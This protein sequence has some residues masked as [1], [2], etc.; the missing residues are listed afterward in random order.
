M[1]VKSLTF[2]VLAF[3]LID[4]FDA[5]TASSK[6]FNHSLTSERGKQSHGGGGGGF[7]LAGSGGGGGFLRSR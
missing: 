6:T 4:F 1:P 7:G 3:S 2:N 5:I